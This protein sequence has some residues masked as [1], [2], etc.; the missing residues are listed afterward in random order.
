MVK[1]SDYGFVGNRSTTKDQYVAYTSTGTGTTW[2]PTGPLGDTS[3]GPDFIPTVG[4]GGNVIAVGNTNRT[5]TG[6]QALLVKADTAGDLEPVSLSAIPGGLIPEETVQSIAVTGSIRSP[7]AARTAT[8]R[9]GGA[10]RAV[11]GAWSPR[12]PWRPPTRTWPGCPP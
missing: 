7:W 10:Y 9:S 4:P 12:W 3:S 11:P 5:K 1:G 6:Q 2:L 8:R